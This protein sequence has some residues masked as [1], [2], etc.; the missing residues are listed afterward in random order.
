MIAAPGG[1]PDRALVA[2]LAEGFLSRLSFG[3]IGFIV[4]LY[5]YRMGL[6]LA[7]LGLLASLNTIVALILKPIM[8]AVAD[9]VGYR[10][11]VLA[12]MTL[13]TVLSLLYALTTMPWQLYGVRS[14]HGLADAVRDPAIN[15]MIAEYG[16]KKA[17]ARS[18]AWYQTARTAA[19]SVG[20]GAA[21][22]LLTVTA[23]NY[24]LIFL[25]AAALSLLPVI[26]VARWVQE[27]ARVPPRAPVAEGHEL[28]EPGEPTEAPSARRTTTLPYVFFGFLV[29]GS[30]SM[31]GTLFPVIAIEYA[32]LTEA[33]AGGLYLIT[34][35]L[36][37]TG[38]L[39]GWLSD[40]VSRNL[41]LSLRSVFNCLSSLLYIA[42]PGFAG[43][44]VGKSLDDLG[45][46]A[47]SPAWGSVMAEVSGQDL[48]RRARLM[49]LLT[50]GEDAGDV[51]APLLAGLVAG[52]WGIGALLGL[53]AGV[54]VAAEAQALWIAHRGR[55][56]DRSPGR[57]RTTGRH[58][59]ERISTW[60][61][62]DLADHRPDREFISPNPGD[63]TG[64]E[65]VTVR[66]AQS[67]V[68]VK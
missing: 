53:R 12:A 33:Q 54:A 59:P 49:G 62:P 35:F 26:V 17:I 44:A 60:Q 13:R 40:R 38:P 47:F 68:R 58:R 56:P 32:G 51:V 48:S 65:A 4:P 5:A 67:L 15:V 61:P 64:C 50:A 7:Q 45:K 55:R 46:A 2:L 9:R 8:G 31:L 10:R 52:W 1:R 42:A 24:G 14:V 22:V 21:G 16:G 43:F 36:A 18:F 39:F 29:S 11:S 25:V 27:P 57:H 28:Q 20:K 6:S 66:V 41:V 19:G 63:V 23:A 30:A 34:P 3:I 37:L